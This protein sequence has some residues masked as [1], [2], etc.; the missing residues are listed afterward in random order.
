MSEADGIVES[1]N[2]AAE[3]GRMGFYERARAAH[4]APLWRVLHGLVTAEPKITAVP[5]HYAYAALR[6]YLMEACELIG[7]EEAERRVMVLENPGLPGQSRITPSLFCG[8]QIILPGEIAPAHKHVA[9]ALRFIVE[10]RDAYS[11]IA[12]EKTMMEAGDFVI[13]PSM[14]WH[15]H[16]NE[17][18]APMVWIDGL[19]MHMVNLFSASFRE[20]YPG[21]THPTLK[22]QGGTMAEVGYN[23]IP[24]GY[25]HASQTSPIFNYPYRRT[26]EALD[27]LSRFRA[28]DACHGFR[29]N[30]INPLT[31]GPAM[32]TISTAMR[33]LPKGFVS[34]PYRSTAGTVFSV[35]EGTG[36]ARVGEQA[37]PL[38]PRDIFVVP[39]W[40]PVTIEAGE[41]LVLFTYSDQIVQEKLDFFREKRGDGPG[42]SLAG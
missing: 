19:D 23:M 2:L 33:L 17:S 25:T 30:Y 32:P 38:A 9:S 22:P 34:A 31:G 4:L 37:F 26:R 27:R 39:S 13:T 35:V 36:V 28:P 14:T 10:G 16:G 6:P 5:A 8:L 41:D 1:V 11:A 7:T 15:D 42:D 3:E 18:D 29:M 21:A 20:N 24:D 40:F 12:G